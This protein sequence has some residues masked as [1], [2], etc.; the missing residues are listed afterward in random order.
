[1]DLIQL[2]F[3]AALSIFSFPFLLIK[4]LLR[5]TRK[6]HTAPIAPGAWPLIG[7]LAFY[8]DAKTTHVAFGE[9][10]DKYGPVFMTKLGSHN[11]LIISSQEVVKE[12]YTVHD[13][14]LDRPSLTASKL[15]GYNDTFMTFSPYGAYWR[16]MRKI[17]TA[18]VLSP[19]VMETFKHS[20]AGEADVAFRDL[21]KRWEQKG[22]LKIGVL[23]DM[24]QEFQY[25]TANMSLMMVSRKRYFGESPNCEIGE[26]RRCGKLI[27]EFIDY[28]DLVLFSDAVPS[29]GWLDWGIKRGMKKTAKGLDK[30]VESWVEEHKNEDFGGG[31]EKDFM[32]L[33]M[34]I[35]K[36]DN[37]LGL[38]D[39]HA[40]IKALCLN[41]VLSGSETS[42]VVLV[43][44]VSLLVNNPD[45]LRKAR[46][47]LD[48]TIGKERVVE[49]SDIKDLV[50]IQAIV[51]ETFRLYPSVPLIA[52]R[53]VMEDFNIVNGNY[54]IPAGTQLM[55][56][57]SKIGS[58]PSLWSDPEKFEPER[59]L[60]SNKDVDFGGQNYKLIAF[61][62]GRRTCPAIHLGLRTVHY[63]LARFLH[64]FDVARPSSDKVDMTQSNGM[65]NLKTTPLEV[66]ITPRLQQSLYYVDCTV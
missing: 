52:Y 38:D 29:L 62:L 26:A 6:K 22:E 21:Y 37:A 9:M 11:V 24:K 53:T 1:M 4:S 19:S 45:V 15:L 32:A 63:I 13:K 35:F 56:N 55:V 50:Y 61:G 58:D 40:T 31:S 33:I 49:E 66:I 10:A 34:E 20:R 48:R 43:W 44:A 51:K 36:R 23:V 2:L 18:E 41:L 59:F 42:I 27:R 17:T 60:T 14:F 12:C 46:E 64:S 47:E 5:P 7:H 65:V 54:N 28:F 3:F 30:V 16:D 8:D 25:L 57:A 39:V